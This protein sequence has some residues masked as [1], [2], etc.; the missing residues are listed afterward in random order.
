MGKF[1]FLFLC[2]VLAS[3]S[4]I[5]QKIGR[6]IAGDEEGP[7]VNA[8]ITNSDAMRARYDLW[9]NPNAERFYF[10]T[11]EF[12]EDIVG[13]SQIKW[14]VERAREGKVV[15]LVLDAQGHKLSDEVILYMIENGVNVHVFSPTFSWEGFKSRLSRQ[16]NQWSLRSRINSLYRQATYRM[17]DKILMNFVPSEDT[18]GEVILGGRNARESHYGID[19]QRIETV[20]TEQGQQILNSNQR[21]EYEHEVMVHDEGMHREVTTYVD[22]FV[23]SD[24]T[25]RVDATALRK[26]L[27]NTREY[28][29]KHGPNWRGKLVADKLKEND[30]F[31][32]YAGEMNRWLHRMARKQN[33]L[34]LSS[35]KLSKDLVK[36]I[37]RHEKAL[38]EMIEEGLFNPRELNKI[39]QDVYG[40]EPAGVIEGIISSYRNGKNGVSAADVM[41][42]FKEI[43]EKEQKVIEKKISEGTLDM[44][45]LKKLMGPVGPDDRGFFSKLSQGTVN[46]I[47]GMGM[48][49]GKFDNLENVLKESDEIFQEY[50]TGGS[51]DWRA[52]AIEV[53]SVKFLHDTVDNVNFRKKSMD[54]FYKMISNCRGDCVWNSQYG[55]L[56][57]EAQNAIENVVKQNSAI[58]RFVNKE[59]KRIGNEDRAREL[60]SMFTE[61]LESNVDYM[62]KKLSNPYLP[63]KEVKD[64][65]TQIYRQFE[66]IYGG[67]RA[68]K[69]ELKALSKQA[70]AKKITYKEFAEGLA[71]IVRSNEDYLANTIYTKP[72]KVERG[73]LRLRGFVDMD[74]KELLGAHKQINFYFMTNDVNS[75]AVGFDKVIHADFHHNIMK[76]FRKMGPGLHVNG[77]DGSGRIHSK[78]AVTDKGLIVSSMNADPRSEKINTEVGVEI[79]T[80]RKGQ[81]LSNSFK[82]HIKSYMVTSK[83]HLVDGQF[84]RSPQCFDMMTRVLRSVLAPIL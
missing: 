68:I 38:A 8:L 48:D 73:L 2:L 66:G 57:E 7:K 50:M 61:L 4:G 79:K 75:W 9:H 42:A 6:F 32:Q 83:K 30:K 46:T 84:V 35:E 44:V 23:E 63:E 56:T 67:D 10:S 64:D 77:M 65:I 71:Q 81:H 45:K 70:K 13:F 43:T 62:E 82:N 28:Q 72:D 11:F 16:A 40:K 19:T 39:L 21:L 53:D 51:R 55:S 12:E 54:E 52:I 59:Y 27:A 34:D 31:F 22:D 76:K 5:N 25:E 17:H 33:G 47:Y 20:R 80:E 58:Y 24:F 29:K 14:A 36:I 37:S 3:C 41:E 74:P 78:V 1:G 18:N 69:S 15:D 60:A 26:R 49:L